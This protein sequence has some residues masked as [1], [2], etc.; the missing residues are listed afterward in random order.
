MAFLRNGLRNSADG[1]CQVRDVG[2]DVPIPPGHHFCQFAVIPGCNQCQTV[3]L[4]GD[5]KR[6]TFRPF[7][8]ILDLLGLGKRQC[9]EFVLLLLSGDLVLRN[10][11][12]RTVR[13]DLPRF[14]FQLFQ[15][16]KLRIPLI[17]G[18]P[19]RETVVIGVRSLV[20]LPDQFLHF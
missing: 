2:P 18:H 11:L 17:I 14:F 20:E 19:F 12:C 16:V 8:K 15:P 13:K 9:G 1:I 4:P 5:P 3:Q 7:G 6:S 10:T